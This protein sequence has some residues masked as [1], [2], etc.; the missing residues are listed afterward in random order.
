MGCSAVGD[1]L[2]KSTCCIQKAWENTGFGGGRVQLVVI[3]R[4]QI[5]RKENS[6]QCIAPRLSLQ[7]KRKMVEEKKICFRTKNTFL[8]IIRFCS[9]HSGCLCFLHFHPSSEHTVEDNQSCSLCYSFFVISPGDLNST[10][11]A[12]N[13]CLWRQ[14]SGTFSAWDI[15]AEVQGHLK[16][17]CGTR[18]VF[19]SA[20]I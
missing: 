18:C 1:H 5:F 14:K 12:Q 8:C 4:V 17:I 3:L 19:F 20:S 2:Q 9:L 6:V 11:S 13:I 7:S 15:F 16:H 10:L